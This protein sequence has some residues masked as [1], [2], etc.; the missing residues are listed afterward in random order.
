M[1]TAT[2]GSST[3]NR[4]ENALQKV[5]TCALRDSVP[6]LTV[7]PLAAPQC[8]GSLTFP[9]GIGSV[10]SKPITQVETG[11]PSGNS[12]G[13]SFSSRSSLIGPQAMPMVGSP[14]PDRWLCPGIGTMG[15]TAVHDPA[16]A[17]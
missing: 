15:F 5:R 14:N 2:N 17:Q 9:P 4:L 8:E 11:F 16:D 7:P 3:W 6:V 13:L 12:S 1:E 10:Q